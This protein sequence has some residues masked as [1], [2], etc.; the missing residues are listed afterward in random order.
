[1]R[2]ILIRALLLVVGL[3]A[4]LTGCDTV[5]ENRPAKVTFSEPKSSDLER[6]WRGG[7]I[8]LPVRGSTGSLITTNDGS[9]GLFA[10]TGAAPN[11]RWPVILVISGCGEPSPV[12]TMKAFAEQGYVAIAPDTKRRFFEPLECAGGNLPSDKAALIRARHTEINYAKRELGK[13]SW[14]DTDNLFLMGTSDG[15]AA[16][17][18]YTGKGFK[19]RILAEW[20]CQGG[21]EVRGIA[22]EGISPVFAATSSAVPTFSGDCGQFFSKSGE[23]QVLVLPLK[24]SSNILLEPIVYTQLLRF[25]D[26]QIFK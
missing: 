1:M 23:S 26:R 22:R 13:F 11:T 16:V 12:T 18:R 20:A 5:D 4:A 2:S 3:S 6:V 24:Y 14:I 25:L 10:L 8:A 21:H 19:A 17:A 7:L 9:S 15:A